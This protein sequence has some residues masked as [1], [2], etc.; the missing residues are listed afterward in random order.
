[1]R[2]CR[3]DVRPRAEHPAAIRRTPAA[4]EANPIVDK[5]FG[6]A[7]THA[8]EKHADIGTCRTAAQEVFCIPSR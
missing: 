4:R 5:T 8:Q 7:V 6:P 3:L 2:R 1:M